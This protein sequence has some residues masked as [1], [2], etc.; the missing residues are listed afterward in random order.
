MKPVNILSEHRREVC[1][2]HRRMSPINKFHQL[3]RFMARID[4]RKAEITSELSQDLLMLGVAIAM[5]Q[6]DRDT[7]DPVSQQFF[8]RHLRLG[9]VEMLNFS[10]I[11]R[12]APGAF[13]DP[14]IELIRKLDVQVEKSGS[15]LR[16]YS[17]YIPKASVCDK[18]HPLAFSFQE[19]IGRNGRT[20][21]DDCDSLDRDCLVPR[22]T[23]YST[24]TFNG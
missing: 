24:N 6:D 7:T 2:Y 15:L 19:R 3:T 4:L 11:V 22:Q 18:S 12:H 16:S 17:K 20:H 14:L 21:F 5:H 23:E 13:D 1:V 9:Q 8:E 10:P